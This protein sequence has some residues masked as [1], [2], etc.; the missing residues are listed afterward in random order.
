MKTSH[1]LQANGHVGNYMP[2]SREIEPW[3]TADRS[4][5]LVRP[6]KDKLGLIKAL[7]DSLSSGY[8]LLSRDIALLFPKFG[9]SPRSAET[10]ATTLMRNPYFIRGLKEHGVIPARE[11]CRG[12]YL[13]F[14]E[15]LPPEDTDMAEVRAML[16]AEQLAQYAAVKGLAAASQA[17]EYEGAH[18]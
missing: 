8:V 9:Y 7:A 13:F 17:R 2:R 14:D 3:G 18:E 6:G 11:R 15:S 16:E 10:Y 12:T 4:D 5:L 1:K